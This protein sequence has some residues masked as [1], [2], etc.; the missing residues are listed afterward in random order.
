MNPTELVTAVQENLKITVIISQ[1]HGFQCIWQ[2]QTGRAG[3]EF[4]NE[5]R[6]RDASTNRLE[7]DYLSIDLAA[8]AESL[9]AR[10]WRVGDP[11]ALGKALGEARRERGPC[12]IV[13]E[14]EKHRFLPGTGV[15][16]DIATAEV[17]GDSV[18]AGLRRQYEKDRVAQRFHYSRSSE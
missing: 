8:N 6:A 15:W 9:G 14:T 1:N 10:A 12:V 11:Q 3:P 18:T 4:G 13:V 16:W 17:S 2:L 7:G 5:F